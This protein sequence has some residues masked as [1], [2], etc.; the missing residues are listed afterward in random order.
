LIGRLLRGHARSS[1]FVSHFGARSP[2][3][4]VGAGLVMVS[5]TASASDHGL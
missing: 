2:L 5:A 3:A 1:A 4:D